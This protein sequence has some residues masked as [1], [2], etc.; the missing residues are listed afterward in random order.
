MGAA[1]LDH[2]HPLHRLA[3]NG[4]GKGFHLR[5]QA[6]I[7]ALHG[8][9][10]HGRGKGV[11]GR[12][13]HVHV[14]I[15]ANGLLT[16][17]DAAEELDGAVGQHLV[18]IHVGLGAGTCLPHVERKMFVQQAV[19]AFLR[20]AV[21]GLRLPGG[22]PPHAGVDPRAGFFDQ[23]EGA[24]DF[25]RHFVIANGKV[26]KRTLRLRAPVSVGRHHDLPHAVKFFA[27][28]SGVYAHR[29]IKN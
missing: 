19:H 1:N 29:N 12:L 14:I 21:N 17:H 24:A 5:Q 23:A 27:F 4:F 28:S 13:A 10:M 8:G 26:L 7:A 16:A 20:G 22:Q 11:V 18:H 9:Q 25:Q 3:F 6:R 15:G 2:V